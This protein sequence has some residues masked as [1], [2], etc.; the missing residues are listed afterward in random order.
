MNKRKHKL[1]IDVNQ[2]PFKYTPKGLVFEYIKDISK[3]IN[4]IKYLDFGCRNGDLLYEL[5]KNKIIKTG[6]GVDLDGNAIA[7]AKKRDIDIDFRLIKKNHKF[8]ENDNTFDI[9]TI[10]GVVEHVYDQ[11]SLLKELKRI[12]KVNGILIV[13][14]PGKHLFSFLDMGNFKF[15]F[16]KLHK[17]FV[18]FKYSNDE[19][20]K[21][22]VSNDFGCIGDIESEKS[23]HE[24]FSKKSMENLIE[25]VENLKILEVNGLGF[26]HR[27][28]N[29]IK[30]FLPNNIKPVMNVLIDWDFKK[31]DKCELIFLLSKTENQ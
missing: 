16:P 6:I 29:N 1:E 7:L 28:F 19:Y 8:K 30:Y 24:H 12:L 18:R 10:V 17:F 22:Y 21:R 5:Q 26:F 2:N 11:I 25:K 15:L 4:D 23:W 13:A 14:V 9:I 27:I 31:Y 3:S 20:N